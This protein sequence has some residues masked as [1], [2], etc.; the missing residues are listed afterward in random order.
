[1][2]STNLNNMHCNILFTTRKWTLFFLLLVSASATGQSLNLIPPVC[3]I[4][5]ND[6][7]RMNYRPAEWIPDTLVNTGS[8]PVSAASA[9]AWSVSL[10]E[11]A[12]RETSYW[13][14]RYVSLLNPERFILWMSPARY[15]QEPDM[16]GNPWYRDTVP[17]LGSGRKI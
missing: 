14:N 2:Y 15:D 7:S 8:D 13:L 12:L 10:P 5:E 4:H 3:S 16:P 11:K 17:S 9:I 1:M 6:S